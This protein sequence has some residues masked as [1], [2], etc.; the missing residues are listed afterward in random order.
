MVDDMINKI[1]AFFASYTRKEIFLLGTIF[2]IIATVVQLIVIDTIDEKIQMLEIKGRTIN[3]FLKQ[4]EY[5]NLEK[6]HSQILFN[7]ELHNSMVF[8]GLFPAND[9]NK[10]DSYETVKDTIF[11][12]GYVHHMERR[13]MHYDQLIVKPELKAEQDS[14]MSMYQLLYD[15]DK[16]IFDRFRQIQEIV[17]MMSNLGVKQL[18]IIKSESDEIVSKMKNLLRSRDGFYGIFSICQIM[19]LILVGYSQFLDE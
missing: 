1:K 18:D 13:L 17:L 2:L 9:E 15:S 16:P 3:D 11:C 6:D 14:I 4:Y 19:G 12:F 8:T 5:R 7:L 10:I